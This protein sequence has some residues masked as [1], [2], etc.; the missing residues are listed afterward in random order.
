[1]G[2]ERPI[3]MTGASVRS[4]LAGHKTQTRRVVRNLRVTLPSMVTSDL[5]FVFRDDYLVAK[6]GRHKATMNQHGAVSVLLDEKTLGVKPGEFEFVC[7]YADGRTRLHLEDRSHVGTW[8]IEPEPDQ[9]LWVRETWCNCTPPNPEVPVQYRADWPEH[10]YGP[11]WHS[12]R[13]MPRW[14][15]RLVLEVRD[16]RLERLQDI[17]G[18]DAFNELGCD[19]AGTYVQDF[20][21]EIRAFARGWNKLNAKR[22]FGWNT[23]PWVWVISFR[24]QDR[25]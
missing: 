1:M 18:P 12:P 6:P 17:T 3:V 7:P 16:V 4:I 5:P 2:K 13:F 22:G 11:R 21:W 23:N 8:H 14:A 25:P 20:G 24:V 19:P 10:D 9:R 15:C